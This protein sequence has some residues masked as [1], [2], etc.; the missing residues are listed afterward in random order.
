MLNTAISVAHL[1]DST[2]NHQPGFLLQKQEV[3]AQ[4]YGVLFFI[5]SEEGEEL[6]QKRN[7]SRKVDAPGGR[8]NAGVALL[9]TSQVL[10]RS[11]EAENKTLS[12]REGMRD[13]YL[14]TRACVRSRQ[15]V[16]LLQKVPLKL[17]SLTSWALLGTPSRNSLGGLRARM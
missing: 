11:Q 15:K 4:K 3:V 2:A 6:L 12:G 1:R 8:L 10:H 14:A 13:T 7:K 17:A 16:R 5:S 9:L